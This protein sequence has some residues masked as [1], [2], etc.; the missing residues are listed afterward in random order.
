MKPIV[1][2]AYSVYFKDHTYNELALHLTQKKYSSIFVLVDENTHTHC[3]AHFLAHLATDI[4]IEVIEIE[5][6][7][8]NKHL[9]TCMGVWE[10]LSELGA[11][12]KSLMINVGGGVVTDLGGFVAATFKRGIDFIQVP[13][14]LLSMVDASVGG[15]TGVDLG[16]LKNQIGVITQPVMVL[17]DP[18]YLKTLPE[19]E[20]RSG[21]A[22]ILK[23]GLIKDRLYWDRVK[24]FNH[25][26]T[27]EDI[28]YTSVQI[29]NEVVRIDP[30]E[31]SYRKIL[32]FGHT[33]GHAIESYYLFHPKYDKL[34]HGEAIAI[35]MILEAHL[36]HQIL[37][38]EI[39]DVEE[40]KKHLQKIYPKIG[41]QKSD[42][43]QIL[44]LL[45]HDKKNAF[46][47]INFVLLEQIGACVLD[48]QIDN[49]QIFEAFDYYLS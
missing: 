25:T 32:N 48:V 49:D 34:L 21:Y 39:A 9:E 14:T 2:D 10:A 17:I 19:K 16:P 40:I 3:L 1:S 28:I 11:D 33:L 43:D 7:E 15:K 45:Q 22:E 8:E 29:K 6:G 26:S 42:I 44:S 47:K 23:H 4:P 35:G 36:S 18:Y 46:G 12:R 5:A 20:Y 41:I 37:K 24:A 13:T 30:T 27:I 38:M 31:Q